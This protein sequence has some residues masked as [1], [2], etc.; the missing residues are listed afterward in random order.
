MAAVSLAGGG[1][2][3]HAPG[4]RTVIAEDGC[5]VDSLA[6]SFHDA[7][8]D[9]A[10]DVDRRVVQDRLRDRDDDSQLLSGKEHVVPRL[11]AGLL[12]A[13]VAVDPVGHGKHVQYPHAGLVAGH[14]GQP[15]GELHK[16]RVLRG[17]LLDGSDKLFLNKGFGIAAIYDSDGHFVLTSSFE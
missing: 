10:H 6:D 8:L 14:V 5:A 4:C 7:G 17:V 12:H 13:G 11:L 1:H 9:F 15:A 16:N 2:D 3:V